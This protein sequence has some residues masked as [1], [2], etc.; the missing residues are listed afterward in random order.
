MT[1]EADLGPLAGT[2]QGEG[3]P[4]VLLHGNSET[5]AIF[6]QMVPHLGGFT[7]I[8]LDSRAHGRS[9]RGQ[10]PLTIQQLAID[11]CRALLDYRAK[12]GQAGPFGLI[13]FS[14]GANI[15]LEIAIHR[16]DLLAAE[17]LLGGNVSP[18]ALRPWTKLGV[19]AVWA[20]ARAAGLVSPAARRQ[21][22][23]FGLMVGQ[24]NVTARQLESV[25]VPT[26][27][28]AGERDVVPRHESRRVARLIPGAEWV[29]LAGQGHMLPRTAPRLAAEL[30]AGFLGP[31]LDRG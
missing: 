24:P 28:M 17:V 21:A 5:G 20:A 30:A 4:V 8:R 6:D 10:R 3:P 16:P 15:G 11:T 19:L 18:L 13:G 25:A 29:E 9:R 22:E 26:M 7:L 1:A 23:V 31:R 2:I 27:I 12:S 14:D